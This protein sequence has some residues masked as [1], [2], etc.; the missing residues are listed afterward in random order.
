MQPTPVFLPGQAHGQRS[1]TGY[2][3]WVHKES[4]T[5]EH[6]QRNVMF[7]NFTQLTGCFLLSIAVHWNTDM[8]LFLYH[9]N[10]INSIICKSFSQ[11]LVFTEKQNSKR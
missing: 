3:P 5:T 7:I 11:I 4:D 6:A 1:L 10:K 2:S 9:Y 8:L